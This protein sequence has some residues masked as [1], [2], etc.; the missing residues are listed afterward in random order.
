MLDAW[1]AQTPARH[2]AIKT[3]SDMIPVMRSDSRPRGR[4]ITDFH[5]WR[6]SKMRMTAAIAMR[7]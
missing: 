4:D 2:T 5:G 7:E 6:R 1:N 3:H